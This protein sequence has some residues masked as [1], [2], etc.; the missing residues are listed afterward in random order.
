M[1]HLY[2]SSLLLFLCLGC[3][4]STEYS[5]RIL[6]AA[7]NSPVEGARCFMTINGKFKNNQTN[8]DSDEM[9]SDSLGNYE[10]KV[11]FKRAEAQFIRITKTGFVTKQ[12]D[13]DYGK[14]REQDITIYPY[15]AY[16][17]VTFE[18]KS[19]STQK[20]F[21]YGV[22]C[23]EFG[24]DR[25]CGPNGCGPHPVA[26]LSQQTQVL[27]VPGGLDID[28]IWDTKNFGSIAVPNKVTTFCPHN[29][30]TYITIPF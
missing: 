2:L 23:S 26:A 27:R 18:N 5:G 22:T 17:S 15:D 6:N 29:D 11:K 8:G 13:I 12:I 1:K 21:W 10:L 25:E 14:C 4:K 16:L 28:I 20:D 3:V 9:N 30:T 7:D 19:S 24:G